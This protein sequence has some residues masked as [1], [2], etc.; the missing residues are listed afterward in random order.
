MYLLAH[1]PEGAGSF[2]GKLNNFLKLPQRHGL[3]LVKQM[4]PCLVS[5][6]FFVLLL[7]E[8][9]YEEE[10]CIHSISSATLFRTFEIDNINYIIAPILLPILNTS[11]QVIIT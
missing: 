1:M 4:T 3:F 9:N 2:N 5:I 7:Y 8:K 11:S 6:H 10:L